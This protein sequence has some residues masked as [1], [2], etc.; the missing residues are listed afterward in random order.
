M[1]VGVGLCRAEVGGELSPERP[2]VSTTVRDH[3]PSQVQFGR[4]LCNVDV[5][6]YSLRG[7]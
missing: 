3:D 2:R 7:R 1:E 4:L 6:T 5:S